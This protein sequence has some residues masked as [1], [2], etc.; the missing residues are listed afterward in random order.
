MVRKMENGSVREYLKAL[1]KKKLAEE[2]A[3]EEARQA[4]AEA[5]RQAAMQYQQQQQGVQQG[6]EQD[7]SKGLDQF[8]LL[9]LIGGFNSGREGAT[10]ILSRSMNIMNGDSGRAT[11]ALSPTML[12]QQQQQVQQ[13]P[14]PSVIGN[15]V[16]KP[17]SLYESIMSQAEGTGEK[18][19]DKTKEA[20]ER[21]KALLRV[22]RN[23]R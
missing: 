10:D 4:D 20:K 2:A 9:K 21:A 8:G 23:A 7:A 16:M 13:Q 3:A 22:I 14:Q 12:P 18:I 19:S 17:Q 6:Y 1:A 11:A 15:A 5:N